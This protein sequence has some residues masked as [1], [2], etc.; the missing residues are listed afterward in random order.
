MELLE[1]KLKLWQDKLV[2]LEADFKSTMIR[3]GEAI[4]M[5]DLRENAAFQMLDEDKDTIRVRI[6][7]IKKIIAKIEDE[8]EAKKS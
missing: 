6:D 8:I 4:A 1:Q 5:G 2:K 7:E 3:R